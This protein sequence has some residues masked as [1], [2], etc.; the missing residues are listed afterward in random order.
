MDEKTARLAEQLKNNPAILTSLMQSRDGRMLMQML[1]QND[2]GAAL[3]QA[4]QSA[5]RG[6]T[7]Q[8]TDMVQGIMRSPEGA[9]LVNR[10]Q[11]TLQ[12]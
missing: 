7:A 12:K 6:N 2:R 10:I 4:I 5:V 9:A 1:T 3:Q 8:M 11:Q